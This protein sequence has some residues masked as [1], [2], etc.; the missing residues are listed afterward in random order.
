MIETMTDPATLHD[1][2][3]EEVEGVLLGNETLVEGLTISLLT[4]G[5]VLLEG[6]PGVAKTTAATPL[7]AR[8]GHGVQS[9]PDDTGRP[10]R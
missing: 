5:H 4:H 10:A 3:R 1:A 2:I 8:V 6:V 7:R 9:N